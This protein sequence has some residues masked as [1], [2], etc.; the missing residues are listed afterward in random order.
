MSKED[1]IFKHWKSFGPR[2]YVR[3]RLN[4][5]SQWVEVDG[6]D[7]EVRSKEQDN[8]IWLHLARVHK[9]SVREIKDIVTAE[10]ERRKANAEVQ[11]TQRRHRS[12]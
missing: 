3:H 12:G 1:R 7:V 11:D 8:N 10:R 9:M 5:E 4:N 6:Y 2:S